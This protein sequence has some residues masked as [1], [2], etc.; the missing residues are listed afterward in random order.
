VFFFRTYFYFSLDKDSFGSMYPHI[1][2]TNS[3]NKTGKHLMVKADSYTNI[4]R[5]ELAST[6]VNTFDTDLPR[7]IS[8]DLIRRILAYEEQIKKRGDLDSRSKRALRIHKHQASPA[9]QAKQPR[10]PKLQVGSYLLREWN[11]DTHRVDITEDGFEWRGKTYKSLSAIAKAITEAH[12]SGPRFFGLT[13][14]AVS[15]G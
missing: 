14:K 3:S 2:T 4:N 9:A 11:H 12:W 6:W 10:N 7:G 13:S 5:T 8:Q 15:N 1:R